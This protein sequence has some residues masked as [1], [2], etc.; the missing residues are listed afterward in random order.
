MSFSSDVKKELCGVSFGKCALAE[1]GGIIYTSG[2]IGLGSTGM[3]LSIHT[4]NEDF[5]RRVFSLEKKCLG[6]ECDLMMK[7]NRMKKRNTFIIVIDGTENVEKT[8]DAI[9]L[10]ID[11]LIHADDEKLAELTAKPACRHAFLRGAFLGCGTMAD[12]AKIYHLEFLT[13]LKELTVPLLNILSNIGITAKVSPR[14][15]SQV[16]YIKGS[17]SIALLLSCMGARSSVIELNNIFI[18]KEIK[19]GVNRR[20]NFENANIDRA[21]SSAMRQISSIQT[22]IDFGRYDGLSQGL[23]E[24]CELRLANPEDTLAELAEAGGI[25]RSCIT[26]RL[27]KID[28]IAKQLLSAK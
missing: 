19:N 12:P 8:F 11:G 10:S 9:G 23:R 16:V 25:S 17:E 26:H 6:I 7:Q 5:M 21:V 13:N 24:A 28:E 15:D 4:E 3:S 18:E 20:V 1:L 27:N 2:I 22:I 14:K